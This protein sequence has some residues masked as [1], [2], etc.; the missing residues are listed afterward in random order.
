MNKPVLV[1]LHTGPIVGRPFGAGL[2]R[3]HASR[4][5]RRGHATRCFDPERHGKARPDRPRRGRDQVV[6]LRIGRAR[7]HGHPRKGGAHRLGCTHL[8]PGGFSRGVLLRRPVL[9][10]APTRPSVPH[11][12]ALRPASRCGAASRV[13]TTSLAARPPPAARC[14]WPV[15]RATSQGPYTLR[16]L[17]SAQPVRV[18][19]MGAVTETISRA[20]ARDGH[21]ALSRPG[22]CCQ[23]SSMR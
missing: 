18:G 21:T 3:R 11:P 9:A 17:T 6:G 13:V 23:V 2:A 5:I 4:A 8:G 10:G 22:S 20:R 12:L 1:Q 15:G 7:V 19:T 16:R 14:G